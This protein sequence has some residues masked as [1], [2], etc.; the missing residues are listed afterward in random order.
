MTKIA[1]GADASGDLT[2]D[3]PVLASPFAGAIF[4]NGL[5]GRLD[6]NG[7]TDA[8]GVHAYEFQVSS[9]SDFAKDFILYRGAIPETTVIIPPSVGLT[10]GLAQITFFWRVQTADNAGNLSAWSPRSFAVSPSTG[11]PTISSIDVD[12]PS[13]TGGAQATGMLQLYDA[14]PAGGFV[15]RLTASHD[16]SQ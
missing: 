15:A 8:S 10:G 11:Q 4:H 12:S 2:A 3:A 7:V 9:R 13:V 5:I 1:L 14:A 6:W 16:R